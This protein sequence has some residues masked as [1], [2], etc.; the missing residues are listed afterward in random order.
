MQAELVERFV[1]VHGQIILNQFQH[2][3]NKAVKGSAFASSL[4]A[5]MQTR[6][7]SKLY[8]SSA[9]LPA[10]RRGNSN[11][12]KVRLHRRPSPLLELLVAVHCEPGQEVGPEGACDCCA[13]AGPHGAQ[14]GEADDSDRDRHGEGHMAVL[15]LGGRHGGRVPGRCRRRWNDSAGG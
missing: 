9:K 13:A 15:L 3:P 6:R 1:V 7:H 11:P 8:S 2:F 5:A 10:A 4:R 12:M 14:P